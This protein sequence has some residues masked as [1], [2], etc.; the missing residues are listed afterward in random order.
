MTKEIKY[1][2]WRCGFGMLLNCGHSPQN[3]LPLKCKS[4]EHGPALDF[5]GPDQQLSSGIPEL[6]VTSDNYNEWCKASLEMI[7]NHSL[8]YV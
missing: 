8:I 2:K 7:T 3:V 5:P 4:R 1:L 6:G